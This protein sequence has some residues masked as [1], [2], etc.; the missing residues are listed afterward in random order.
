MGNPLG[1]ILSNEMINSVAS[2][3]VEEAHHLANID[4]R[5]SD[6]II[7]VHLHAE[8]IVIMI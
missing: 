8:F 5:I 7:T 3:G 6:C 2:Y 4:T 1:Y